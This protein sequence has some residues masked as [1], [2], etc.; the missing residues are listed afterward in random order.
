M[1]LIR[2]EDICKKCGHS[3]HEHG[4]NIDVDSSKL[5]DHT[6]CKAFVGWWCDKCKAIKKAIRVEQTEEAVSWRTKMTCL[7]CGGPVFASQ[8]ECGNFEVSQ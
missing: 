3:F 6:D 2:R 4:W 1:T 8:C 7:E 5:S